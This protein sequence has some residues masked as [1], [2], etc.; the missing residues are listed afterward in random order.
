[1]LLSLQLTMAATPLAYGEEEAS[2]GDS[3]TVPAESA[4]GIEPNAADG[5]EGSVGRED[6][7]DAGALNDDN[8]L[9]GEDAAEGDQTA[10]DS[11]DASDSK[12]VPGADG[13]ISPT[14]ASDEL[15]LSASDFLLQKEIDRAYAKLFG[16]TAYDYSNSTFADVLVYAEQYLGLPYVWGGKDLNRDGG[17]DC[18]GFVSWVYNYVC[19]MDIN[20]DYTNAAMLYDEWCT[21]ISESE[22]RPGD[23]V[24][25]KGTYQSINYISHVGIYCGNG[26]M[27]DAGDP[28]GYHKVANVENMN[29]SEA[30]RVYG[31]LVTLSDTKLTF[32][33]A[34]VQVADQPYKGSAC[35]PAP[36]VIVAGA[37]LSEGHDYT[38]SYQNNE[39]PGTATVIIT[40]VNSYAGQEIQATFDIFTPTLPSGYYALQPGCTSTRVLD[41]YAGS[42]DPG[43]PVH[44]YA[45]NDSGA[46]HF[47]VEAL[48]NG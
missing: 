25:F 11:P 15:D 41:V 38:V 34:Q 3:A 44:L 40:G 18:S 45:S 8:A 1:M 27:I 17:F 10:S 26:V 24:F 42:L 2:S 31:R 21:P 13:P 37:T 48:D 47:Y 7:P 23:I 33:L 5:V 46:Q 32:E 30:E 43:A 12:P 39:M 6:A 16:R 35:P 28:I 9:E 22:A 4:N 29:G 19:G 14:D 20:S 36:V